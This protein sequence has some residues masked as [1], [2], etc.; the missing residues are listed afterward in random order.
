MLKEGAHRVHLQ[1]FRL[2]SFLLAGHIQENYIPLAEGRYS[3]HIL[4]FPHHE[5]RL[6]PHTE[7]VPMRFKSHGYNYSPM[8]DLKKKKRFPQNG[9]HRWRVFFA[10][11]SDIPLSCSL[12]DFHLYYSLKKSSER[13]V[14]KEMGGLGIITFCVPS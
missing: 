14:S 11:L 10:P 5:Y 7:R 8:L 1:F 12:M 9:A 6:V 4:C 13:R 2:S 3:Y